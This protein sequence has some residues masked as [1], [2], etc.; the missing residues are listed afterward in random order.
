MNAV[1]KVPRP[2]FGELRAILHNCVVEGLASQNGVRG[3]VHGE[4]RAH[5]LGRFSWV[6]SLSPA[7]GRRL[8][9]EFN[10]IR[11]PEF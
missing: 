5:L 8:R 4:F 11:W 7:R 1:P 6:E 9:N 3:P 2:A 10:R